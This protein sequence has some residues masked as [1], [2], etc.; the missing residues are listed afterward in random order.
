MAQVTQ[1]QTQ[2]SAARSRDAEAEARGIGIGTRVVRFLTPY[3]F[4]GPAI[5]LV[6]VLMLWPFLRSAYLSFTDFGGIRI[7]PTH[8]LKSG[9]VDL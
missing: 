4:L 5:A 7:C 3:L 9:S 8:W 1:P 6:G 2:E